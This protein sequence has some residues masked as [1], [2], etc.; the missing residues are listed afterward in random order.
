MSENG[1]EF[2]IDAEVKDASSNLDDLYDALNKIANLIKEQ[3]KD[4]VKLKNTIRQIRTLSEINTTR[5]QNNLTALNNAMSD[6]NGI[7]KSKTFENFSSQ[8]MAAE[9]A[10]NTL[11]RTML[12]IAKINTDSLKNFDLTN[13]I[14]QMNKF[15]SLDDKAVSKF[16]TTSKGI[17]DI[18]NV[19]ARLSTMKVDNKNADINRD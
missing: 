6:T 8:V 13:I 19:M 18:S 3:F 10:T 4:N 12:S 5:L 15:S 16:G 11:R 17:K 7:F 14:N 2:G 1:L 9:N